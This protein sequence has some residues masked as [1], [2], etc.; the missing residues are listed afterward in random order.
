[1]IIIPAVDIRHGRCVRLSQGRADAET[2]YGD[3]PS[4]MA[5]HWQDLGAARLHVVDLDGAFEKSPRNAL[6][7]EKILKTVSVPVSVG[8]G[9]RNR[10]IFDRWISLG[11]DRVVVGTEAVKNPEW[12]KAAALAHP[13]R[14]VL[15]IDAKNGMVAVEGWTETTALSAIDLALRFQG[16]PVAAVHFTDIARDGMQTGVNLTATADFARKCPFPVVASGGV[17]VIDDIE[18]LL[19]LEKLGVTGVIT[20]RALYAKTLSLPEAIALAG[21]NPAS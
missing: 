16:L 15:G 3:D 11:V 19:P 7:V 4:A 6:A 2:V 20:G 18:A 12:V 13:G 5:L 9:V 17:S 10:E 14:L 8:G 1:M 21:K